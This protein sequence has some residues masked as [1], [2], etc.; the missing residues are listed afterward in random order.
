VESGRA[1]GEPLRHQELVVAIAFSTDGRVAATGSF[2]ATVQL[3]D[4]ATGKS[5]G[6]S[7]SHPSAVRGVAFSPDGKILLSQTADGRVWV[8]D[9]IRGGPLREP[10]RLAASLQGASFGPGGNS[11]F[12]W[13]T[14]MAQLWEL[15]RSLE[16][17]PQRLVTWA[18]L[19]SGLELIDD[20]EVVL[21]AAAW[22]QRYQAL[23]EPGNWP[24]P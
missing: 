20:R 4:T 24:R 12:L 7:F 17:P 2:D 18:Q 9:V 16:G 3:W 11:V 19:C 10:L 15:P 14:E 8:W 1:R 23:G 13:G 5:L 22:Q 6:K 21:D